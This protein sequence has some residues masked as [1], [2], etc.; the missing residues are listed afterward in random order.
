MVSP[1]NW[2]GLIFRIGGGDTL[3]SRITIESWIFPVHINAY[4]LPA[5]SGICGDGF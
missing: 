2:F 4:N 5:I 3:A 1:H